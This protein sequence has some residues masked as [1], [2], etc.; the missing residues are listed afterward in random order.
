MCLVTAWYFCEPQGAAHE[1]LGI[2]CVAAWQH[3]DAVQQDELFLELY[4]QEETKRIQ[5]PDP[6]A[7]FAYS[8]EPLSA[9]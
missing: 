6:W 5:G 1:A 3:D 2:C 8:V 7:A 9:T 4:E